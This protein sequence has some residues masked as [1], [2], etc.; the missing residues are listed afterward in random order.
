MFSYPFFFQ[1]YVKATDGCIYLIRE[2]VIRGTME[3]TATP[4]SDEELVPILQ[5]LADVC[6]VQHFPQADDLR[7]TLWK[8]VPTIAHAL[9]KQRFKSKY[10]DIFLDLMFSNLDSRSANQLSIHAAGQCAEELASLVDPGIFRGRLE[11]YQRECFDRVMHERQMMPKGPG[12]GEI[13]SPFGPPG[14]LDAIKP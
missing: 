11:D 1:L 6:R 10:L 7:A 14:L 3:G 2:L 9:G 4:S 13:F 12:A 5:E 8:S